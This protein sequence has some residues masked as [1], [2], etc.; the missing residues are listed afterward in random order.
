[1]TTRTQ[2]I[3]VGLFAVVTAALIGVVLVVF[4]G[5]KFWKEHDRY[6][7]E[8]PGSVY[9]LEPGAPVYLNGVRV[10]SVEEIAVSREDLKNV[11]VAISLERGTPIRENTRAVLQY[12][13]ITG[14]K[15]IDL[16]GGTRDAPVLPIG[17]TITRGE[18]ALDPIER[19]AKTIADR[20]TVLLARANQL[21]DNLIEI[22]NPRGSIVKSAEAT[23]GNLAATSA[24]LRTMV[25]ENRAALRRS[26]ATI[27]QTTRSASQMLDG[28]ITQL[29]TNADDFVSQLKGLV[30]HNQGTLRSAVTDLRQATR[31]FKDLA[32]EVRQ[33]PSRLLFS[34]PSSDRK[35]P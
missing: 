32:R 26:I 31:S 29:I 12:A 22:S 27:D 4:G 18:T 20:T 16:R 11:D 15:E 21:L 6:R 3:R 2:K 17:G 8:F 9:G 1:M 23:A 7:V 10:G 24:T 19:Q 28:Q 14:L 33:R 25:G 13:G 5:F 30:E 35:L 34:K